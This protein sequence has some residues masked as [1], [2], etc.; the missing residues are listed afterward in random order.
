MVLPT[1]IKKA[2]SQNPR[3]LVYFGKPKSG[4][5]TIAAALPDSLLVDLENGS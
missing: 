4:K 2:T 5:T 3:F 1:E